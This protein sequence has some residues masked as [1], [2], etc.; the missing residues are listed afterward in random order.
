MRFVKNTKYYSGTVYEWNLPTGWTCPFAKECLVKV[1]KVSGK[2]TN[3]SESFRCYSANAERFPAV[4]NHR[5][6]NFEHVKNGNKPIIPIEAKAIRIHASGDFFNQQYFD[7]WIEIA[8]DNPDIEFWAYTKSLKFWINRLAEIPNN[9]ELTAS[10]GGNYDEIILQHNLKHTIVYNSIGDVPN[11]IPI[12]NNDDCARDKS[13]TV[14]AL[15]NN[16]VYKK[17]NESILL[18]NPK[19]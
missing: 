12:D 5:W 7:M 3:K 11:G 8:K 13:I 19:K 14:F 6:N 1:D 15:L 10:Y 17:K 16:F 4:R 9:L 2:F 18:R